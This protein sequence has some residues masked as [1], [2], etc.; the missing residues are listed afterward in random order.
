MNTRGCYRH[1]VLSN[2]SM[3]K[4]VITRVGT[5]KSSWKGLNT[6]IVIGHDYLCYLCFGM[7]KGIAW[8]SLFNMACGTAIGVEGRMIK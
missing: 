7:V 4:S 3:R 5:W 2:N 1:A 6:V 8:R